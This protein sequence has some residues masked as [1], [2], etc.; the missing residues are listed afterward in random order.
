MRG[1][2]FPGSPEHTMQADGIG[3]H[4]GWFEFSEFR[5]KYRSAMGFFYTMANKKFAPRTRSV[6]NLVAFSDSKSTNSKTE[7]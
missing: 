1:K 3:I 2:F 5:K 7:I 6:F 4:N